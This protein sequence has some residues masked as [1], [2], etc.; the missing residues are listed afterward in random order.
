MPA[1]KYT[2]SI[3]GDFPNAKVNSEILLASD[4]SWRRRESQSSS[5]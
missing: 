2:Y 5:S 1:T 3:S 4:S